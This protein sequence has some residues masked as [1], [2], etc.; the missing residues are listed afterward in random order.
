M[1]ILL[2]TCVILFPSC[3]WLGVRPDA[4]RDL[5]SLEGFRLATPCEA[6]SSDQFS[7][8][9]FIEEIKNRGNIKAVEDALCLIPK[10]IRSHYVLVHSSRSAQGSRPEAPRAIFY[11]SKERNGTYELEFAIS[12]NGHPDDTNFHNIEVLKANWRAQGSEQHFEFIDIEFDRKGNS[13]PHV[14]NPN[15]QQCMMCH[16]VETN[17][18]RAIWD[19]KGFTPTVYG[20]STFGGTIGEERHINQFINFSKKAP[21]H[22]RYK[23]LEGLERLSVENKRIAHQEISNSIFAEALGTINNRRIS[24]LIRE[25][26]DYEQYKYAIL[27]SLLFCPKITTFVPERLHSNHNSLERVDPDFRDLNN[28]QNILAGYKKYA[29]QFQS[30]NSFTSIGQIQN[31]ASSSEPDIDP[32]LLP[33][34]HDI[35]AKAVQWGTTGGMPMVNLRWLI[36]GRGQNMQEWAMDVPLAGNFGFYRLINARYVDHDPIDSQSLDSLRIAQ[37]LIESDLPLRFAFANSGIGAGIGEVM[38]MF[39]YESDKTPLFHPE[40][41]QKLCEHLKKKSLQ[42]LRELQ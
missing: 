40:R 12:F 15:P 4:R 38:R 26:V 10:D 32:Q 33:Y 20:A 22:T 28:A 1:R 25:T 8:N 34:L 23:Y 39:R 36:E 7:I 9:S 24:Q 30:F 37:F 21:T 41:L 42:A 29:D 2:Y 27:G 17:R 13:P 6:L 5:T 35:E 18:A 3:N 11:K 19:A 14:S 31:I 16:G